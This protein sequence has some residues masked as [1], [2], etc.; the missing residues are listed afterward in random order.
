MELLAHITGED[1]NRREQSLKEHCVMTA[2]Y[3]AE[4]VGTADCFHAAYLAGLLHDAGKGKAE[5][6]AYIEA[7]FRGE[8]V[9]R[10]SIN[11]TF[12]GAI[13]LLERYHAPGATKW[14]RL[15]CEIIAY[16]AGAHHG[17]FDCVDLDGG[18]GFLYR[19]HKD[20]TEICYEEAMEN[21]FAQVAAKEELEE[22]FR[23]ATTEIRAFFEDAAHL[24]ARNSRD[25]FFQISMLIRLLLSA[26]IYGDRR[27]TGEFMRQM[28]AARDDGLRWE[29]R[30]AFFEKK[31]SALPADSVLNCIR[32]EISEQCLAAAERP[33]GIYRLNVP[34]G[35]GKTLCSLRFALAHAKRFKKRRIIFIIPLLSVLDQNVKVIRDY[36]PD[37]QTVLEHHSNVMREKQQDEELDGYEIL[38]ESW[39]TPIIVSTMVQLLDILFAGRTSAIQRM[40]ALCDSVIVIDEVQSLPKKVTVMFNMALNFLQR[41]GNAT[42]VLSSATQPCFEELKWPLCLADDPDLVRLTPQQTAVF[43]RAEIL[44]CT[45]QYGMTLEGCAA[46]CAERTQEHASLL[47]ICNTKAEA[48]SLY[49]KL[50]MRAEQEG[51]DIF[52]L[53]T[54][55]CQEHRMER[56]KSIQENLGLLQKSL[57][58]GEAPRK[59]ICISTQLI[60]AGVDLSFEGVVRVLAGIDNLAQAAG[61][62]NRSNEYGQAGKVYL[63]NLQNENLSMLRE[64]Q[65][66]QNST[67]QVL[68]D[69]PQSGGA[70]VIGEQA[71]RKFYRYLYEEIKDCIEYPVKATDKKLQTYHLARLLANLR[72][73][74]ETEENRTYILH[75][76]FKTA[77]DLFQVFDQNTTDILVP[78]GKGKLL[79]ERLLRQSGRSGGWGE[80]EA[81]LRDLK[82]FTISVYDWQK[83]K[84]EQAGLLISALEGRVLILNELAYDKELGLTEMDSLP[85]ERLVL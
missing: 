34:T 28:R 63:I 4:S 66:A 80:Y 27:D 35:A 18:N 38:T 76:P 60:E 25:V 1:G 15:T 36:L 79:I 65:S 41:F 16:A 10:G 11:H 19:L 72:E 47:V 9:R 48:S 21:F 77:G 70:S 6:V 81:L 46:F 75:Q 55:M 13:W 62:C 84:L 64:I 31:L 85:V 37:P 20:R 82:L 23:R 42:I 33:C 8:V 39:N 7:A 3:A 73:V 14:E 61:R 50:C 45:D 54:A 17:L 51:W 40:Q 22:L 68:R 12:A 69:I 29:E 56:L 83:Q 59:L 26:V 53:S 78:Y 57:H 5:Y 2:C 49:K 32:K 52:H 71:T 44:N 74:R 58:E 67:R 43:E 30:A 24:Y